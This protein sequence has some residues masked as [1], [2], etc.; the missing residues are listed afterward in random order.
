MSEDF[1]PPVLPMT[2]QQVFTS[3]DPDFAGPVATSRDLGLGVATE[4]V[5]TARRVRLGS[6]GAIAPVATD[7]SAWYSFIYILAGEVTV[8]LDGKPLVLR[9]HD[10]I[11]QLPFTVDTVRAAS[12]YLEFLE[13]QASDTEATRCILPLRPTQTVSFDSPEAHEIGT[14]P[15]SFF[16]Y[17]DLGVAD[18]TNRQIEVQ[19]VRAQRAKEGG[20]GWHSHDMAQLTYGLKGW[21]MLDVEG[22]GHQVCHRPGDGLSIPAHWRHNASSFSDDYWALQLQIPADYQTFVREAPEPVSAA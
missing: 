18:A 17:R 20:T 3:E 5:F 2:L 16:D 8:T 7:A 1:A 9:A 14:G 21:G 10:A 15:R 22:V 6:D 4:G 19:V 13:M 11:S 12:P